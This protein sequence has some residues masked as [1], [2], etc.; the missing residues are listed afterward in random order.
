M[1]AIEFEVERFPLMPVGLIAQAPANHAPTHQNR[2]KPTPTVPTPE[3]VNNTDGSI[4]FWG[5]VV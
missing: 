2:A 5:K 4:G 1:F 3:S